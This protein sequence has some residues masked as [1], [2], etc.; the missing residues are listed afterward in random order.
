MQFL[1]I[2]AFSV[3]SVSADFV[4]T[5]NL[6]HSRSLD[7]LMIIGLRRAEQPIILPSEKGFTPTDCKQ[8]LSIKM[9]KNKRRATI[10]HQ[11]ESE[12]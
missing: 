4:K 2:Y 7:W 11:N 6:M 12:K 3:P 8:I 10:S 9:Q 1:S 5:L